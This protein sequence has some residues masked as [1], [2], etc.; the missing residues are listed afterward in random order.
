MSRRP[1]PTLFPVLAVLAAAPLLAD[2]VPPTSPPSLQAAR[3]AAPPT[4]DGD[5]LD[6]PAWSAVEPASGFWQT[7]PDEGQPA[8]EKTEV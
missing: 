2:S 7:T 8:T 5:V 6:D 3:L 1:H 4:L